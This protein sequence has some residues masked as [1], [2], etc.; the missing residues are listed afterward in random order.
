MNLNAWQERLATHFG[1]MRDKRNNRDV[2]A[3]VYALEHGL[4]DSE[5]ADLS[6]EIHAFLRNSGPA[7]RHYLAW[8]VYSAEIGY[9]YSGEEY[10]D[11]FGRLT[12]NWNNAFR[13]QIRDAYYDFHVNFKATRPR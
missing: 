8:V 3:T 5:I 11:T 2:H 9:Q 6:R 4:D 12:P 1:Q 10:W 13:D 7:R